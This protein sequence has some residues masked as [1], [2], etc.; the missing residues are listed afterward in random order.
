VC[1]LLLWVVSADVYMREF[2]FHP[3]QEMSIRR[4]DRLMARFEQAAQ[5]EAA[6]EARGR[7]R[8]FGR[9]R[10]CAAPA[11]APAAGRGRGRR[12]AAGAAPRIFGE[13]HRG[14]EADEEDVDEGINAEP[15]Q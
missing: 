7:G 4:S 9:G 10:G 2:P 6:A 5:E 13:A 11:R 12:P 15:A 8:P 3:I 1:I 14:D